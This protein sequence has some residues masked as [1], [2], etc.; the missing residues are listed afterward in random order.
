MLLREFIARL[1]RGQRTRFRARLAEAHGVS[2]AA[3][4]KWEAYPP[5]ED[6][7]DDKRRSMA[8]RHPSDLAA[9][10]ITERLTEN[11]VTALDLRPEC[12]A[13]GEVE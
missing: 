1:P 4:R 5:P 9:I 8:R 3:V 10:R 6:W 2:V 11:L 13:V 12:W 7:T